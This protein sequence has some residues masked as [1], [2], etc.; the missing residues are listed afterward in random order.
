MVGVAD[1]PRLWRLCARRIQSRLLS[2]IVCNPRAD[3]Q[4]E[5]GSSRESCDSFDRTIEGRMQN[6]LGLSARISYLCRNLLT[7]AQY[8]R[9]DI[10]DP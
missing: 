10:G 4:G 2:K 8:G 6:Q 9:D 5:Y 3:V 1:T 7:L